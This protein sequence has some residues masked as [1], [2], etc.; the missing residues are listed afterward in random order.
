M[1]SVKTISRGGVSLELLE[2]RTIRKEYKMPELICYGDVAE[3]T[4]G[5]TWG[6]PEDFVSATGG[7]TAPPRFLEQR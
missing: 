1:I 4:Q 7:V 3:L 6:N 2:P 5:G